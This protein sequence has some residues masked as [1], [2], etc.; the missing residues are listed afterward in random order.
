MTIYRSCLYLSGMQSYRHDSEGLQSVTRLKPS[1]LV[2]TTEMTNVWKPYFARIPKYSFQQCSKPRP[3]QKLEIC[4]RQ[5]NGVHRR[6]GLDLVQSDKSLI[7]LEIQRT[8]ERCF[9]FRLELSKIMI[10]ISDLICTQSLSPCNALS[11]SSMGKVNQIIPYLWMLLIFFH[12]SLDAG[13]SL[14]SYRIPVIP[15]NHKLCQEERGCWS[16][17]RWLRMVVK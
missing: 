8:I 3:V 16:F 13:T 12:F 4:P 10:C 17:P 14:G 15:N 2:A 9:M 7:S 5:H 11:V 1:I 6:R